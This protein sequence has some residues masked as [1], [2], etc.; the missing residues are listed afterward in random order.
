MSP[1]VSPRSRGCPSNLTIFMPVFRP[2]LSQ[3]ELGTMS[4]TSIAGLILQPKRLGQVLIDTGQRGADPRI[5]KLFLG[6]RG[7]R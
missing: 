3:G 1:G 2:A 4:L 6:R 5:F 7:G